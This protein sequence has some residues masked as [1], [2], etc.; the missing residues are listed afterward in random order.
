[1]ERQAPALA[2]VEELL[3]EATPEELQLARERAYEEYLSAT[4]VAGTSIELRAEI[5]ERLQDG[6]PEARQPAEGQQAPAYLQQIVTQ[7]LLE[8]KLRELEE[9]TEPPDVS[10]HEIRKRIREEASQTLAV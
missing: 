9:L 4:K 5:Q 1:M 3:E 8:G 10:A 6:E 2:E 7:I